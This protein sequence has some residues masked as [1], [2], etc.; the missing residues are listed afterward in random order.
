MVEIARPFIRKPF[1]LAELGRSWVPGFG[2][3]PPDG[4]AGQVIG[5]RRSPYTPGATPERRT[6]VPPLLK[7]NSSL[8]QVTLS[9]NAGIERNAGLKPERVALSSQEVRIERERDAAIPLAPFSSLFLLD[10]LLLSA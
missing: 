5:K 7:R 1:S 4:F 2:L 9:P 8:S 6:P 3:L 10:L